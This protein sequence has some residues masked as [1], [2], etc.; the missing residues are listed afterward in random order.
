[1]NRELLTTIRELCRDEAAFEQLQQILRSE[2]Y[3]L[4]QEINQVNFQID[5]QKALFRVIT[6]LREPLNLDMLFQATAAEV[7]QLLSADRVGVFRFYPNSG[8]DDGEFVSEDVD[9][10][11]SAAITQKIHDHCFGDQFAIH[12]Q[13]GRVQNVA[14]I[15]E[16][17]LSDCHIQ[18]LSQFQ[19]QANLVVPLLQ[20]CHLWGLLCI[21]QCRTPRQWQATEV[22]FVQQIAHHL[23]VALQQAELLSELR[24]EVHERQQAE[25]RAQ[26]LNQSMQQAIV[27][28]KAVNRE[29]EAFSYSVSHDLRAPLRSIDGFSQ[30][31]LED[32]LE[33]L[34]ETGQ[35]YLR[36][37]RA[38]T[39]RMGQ[40]IDDLLTLSRVTRSD[41]RKESVDLSQLARY[42]CTH[43]QQTEPDR[44][45]EFVMHDDLVTYGDIRLLQV[46]LDNLLNNAWKF[47][48]KHPQARIEFGMLTSENGTPV[49]FVRDNGVGFDMT[50]ID[51]LFKPF[52]RLH[53]MQE[54]PG[55]GIGLATVQRIIH[56]HGGQVWAE[57][58]IDQG[59][60]FYFTIAVEEG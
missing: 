58:A 9:P 31:L 38:A 50:F 55:N 5:Q 20:G 2:V 47:T 23:S 49:Y 52:Q 7:R 29:L 45:V 4:Q 36:R 3:P 11:F 1:M 40:L 27:E 51:K 44:S 54:F 12:Y 8:W 30:A 34:D 48:S 13:S 42:I 32:Y 28:L 57:G 19:V 59:A 15:Y 60:T 26:R 6:R 37:I 33:Q 53:G 24:I 56:R 22:E 21:H 14:N 18:I 46:V 39:Q 10:E 43:L 17:G 25:Q 35:D 16:A 41:M